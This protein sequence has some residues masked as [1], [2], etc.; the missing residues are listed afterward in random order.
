VG[1]D[2]V[3]DGEPVIIARRHGIARKAFPWYSFEMKSAGALCIVTPGFGLAGAVLITALDGLGCGSSPSPV[4]LAPDGGS[5]ETV[6]GAGT[7]DAGDG[8][9]TPSDAGNSSDGGSPESGGYS[10]LHAI[11]GSSGSPGH[12]VDGSGMVVQLHGA[13]RSGTEFACLNGNFFDGPGDQ[14]G[15]DAMKTWN[16][17]AVRVPLNADCWLGINGVPTA[18]AGSNYQNAITTWVNLITMNG[19]VAIVDLHWTAPGSNLANAQIPMADADHSPTF[20]S[21]VAKAFAGNGSVVFD[22]F[23]EPYITDWSC[24]VS[25]G[26]CAQYNGSNYTVAGMASLLQAVRNAGAQNLVILGGLAYSSDMSQWVASVNSIPTLA[27]PLDGISIANVA[28]SWHAYDFN[29]EQSGCPSQYNGYSSTCNTAAVTAMNTSVTTVL[30]AGFPLIIGESGITPDSAST[31][32]PF[33]AAQITELE[34]WYDNLLTWAEGEGQSYLAWSWNTDTGPVLLTD[35]TG[36]PSPYFG[37][38]YQ[39]HLKKF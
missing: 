19:M 13:D 22:L 7:T 31:A 32:M 39:T 4:M 28:V 3:G 26:S 29:S 6:D 9:S 12:I 30:A 16:I 15:I 20:W 14:T 2:V 38:T 18:S 36:T 17:N 24:W 23:N 1:G 8:E 21:Q 37:V 27:A 11:L 34:N 10:G 5:S 25:G 33:S 35:Y